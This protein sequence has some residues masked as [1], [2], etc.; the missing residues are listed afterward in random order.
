MDKTG[1]IA[2]NTDWTRYNREIS[3]CISLL[4]LRS[5][6]SVNITAGKIFPVNRNSYKNVRVWFFKKL[7]IGISTKIY[8]YYSNKNFV[9]DH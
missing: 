1:E 3:V 9:L 5:K 4:I 6:K 7:K 8:Q 2:Y